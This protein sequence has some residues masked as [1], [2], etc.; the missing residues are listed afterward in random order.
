MTGA[1]R[2][3]T[4]RLA[5]F[6]AIGI[7]TGGFN[8]PLQAFLPTFYAT[9][10]GLGIETVGLVFLVSR[11]WSAFS[12][13]IV[14]WL[15]DHTSSRFGKR[16]SWIM[17]GGLLFL[18]STVAIFIPPEGVGVA[19]LGIGLLALCL[20]WTAVSTPLYAWGGELSDDPKE[21]AR[22]QAF[23]QT[24]VSLGIFLVLLMPSL[25]DALG[26]GDLALRVR[27]MG[28]FVAVATIVGLFLIITF[29]QETPARH[30]SR[31]RLADQKAALAELARD[32]LLWR[33]IASDFFVSLGQGARGAVFVFVVSHYMGLG[34]ASILLLIQFLFGILAAPLWARIS[35]RLGR[36]NTLILAEVIQVVINL[37]LLLLTP[38]RVELLVGLVVAQGLMQGSGNLMLRAMI[39]DISDRH[40]KA[41]GMERA[42]LLSSVFNVTTNAAMALSVAIAFFVIGQFGFNPTGPNDAQ[43]LAGLLS[44]FAVGPAIGHAI[45][46]LL[47]IRF[48]RELGAP[49][50]E[51]KVDEAL[52]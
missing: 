31:P 49:R 10:M 16:K 52:V 44:F 29:F 48:P 3:S 39:Y 46:A 45:S 2:L 14:G 34:I 1:P 9:T 25:F 43:A 33:I 47:I 35:Y 23:I 18:V 12:D 8:I 11:L 6:S 21:R 19:W 50:P 5:A 7:A 26:I 4:Q 24:A 38:E 17:G 37:A 28:L 20:G 15:S 13:P 41:T 51:Q 40:R 42:G 32:R 22:I 27:A 30:V 36:P